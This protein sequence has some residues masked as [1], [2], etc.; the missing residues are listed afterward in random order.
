MAA[1]GKG[2]ARKGRRGRVVAFAAGPRRPKVAI[3]GGAGPLGARF[4]RA[5]AARGTHDIVVFDL[6]PPPDAP[7]EIRHRFLDLNL[8]H[9][10]GPSSSSCRK[11]A[12]RRSCTSPRSGARP[13]TRRTRTS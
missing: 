6:V 13:G 4:V 5:L 11:S 10:D 12:P 7:S 1:A 8:P 2:S 9:S 3:T